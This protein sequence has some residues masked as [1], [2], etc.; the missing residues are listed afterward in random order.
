MALSVESRAAGAADVILKDGGTLRLRP[1]G[2]ADADALLAF[3]EGLSAHSLYQRFHGIRTVEPQ[4]AESLLEPDWVETG[5]ARGVARRPG[6]GRRE[7]RAATRP[8]I[9]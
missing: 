7:L 5:R 6:R 2:E 8:W 1:P 3:F 9:G 4:L